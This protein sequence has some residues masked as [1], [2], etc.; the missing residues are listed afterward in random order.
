[1]LTIFMFLGFHKNG[2]I[3]SCSSFEDV[4]AHKISWSHV[5]LF[6]FYIHL[7]SSDNFRFG[8]VEDT[9]IKK[10]GQNSSSVA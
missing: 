5:E 7:R 4:S 10:C 8:M 3:K 1:M 2:R 6:K 9:R